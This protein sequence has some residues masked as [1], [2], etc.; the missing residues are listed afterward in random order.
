MSPIAIRSLAV[1]VFAAARCG[2]AGADRTV[3]P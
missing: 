2:F 1:A 3:A